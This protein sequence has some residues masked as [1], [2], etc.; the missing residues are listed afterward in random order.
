MFYL[1][2]KKKQPPQYAYKLDIQSAY[3]KLF[4]FVTL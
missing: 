3:Y 2:R 4:I 1:A